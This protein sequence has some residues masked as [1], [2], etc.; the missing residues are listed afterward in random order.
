MNANIGF[1]DC[2]AIKTQL[3]TTVFPGQTLVEIV[4]GKRLLIEYHRGLLSYRKEEIVIK[5]RLGLITV[6][7]QGMR[8]ESM[9]S[10][11]IILT[12]D[13]HSVMLGKGV[14]TL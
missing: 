1:A 4:D 12:G 9:R 2:F 6:L 7:G 10:Q 13:I 3:N 14:N 11:Q 5:A 8:I